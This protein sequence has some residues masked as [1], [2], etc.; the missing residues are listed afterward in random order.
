LWY[1]PH[2]LAK[3]SNSR[4]P[5]ERTSVQRLE[6]E[7]RELRP[8]KPSERTYH[9][10]SVPPLIPAQSP[11]VVTSNGVKV[12]TLHLHDLFVEVQAFTL[13][14]L[15][16]AALVQQAVDGEL[17]RAGLNRLLVNAIDMT[18]APKEVNDYMWRWAHTNSRLH[19]IAVVNQ[20]QV[21]RVAVRMR[22]VAS[23][24]RLAA[25]EQRS[26]AIAWLREY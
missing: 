26:E 13:P 17:F 12:A 7:I 18:I 5:A 25:F 14:T 8:A 20:S 2:A 15:A 21:M 23:R 4:N 1:G 9:L 22:A 10:A 24:Q 19:K 6:S 11:D 3:D 16:G